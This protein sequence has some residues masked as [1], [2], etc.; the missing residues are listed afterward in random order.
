VKPYV[1]RKLRF[2]ALAPLVAIGVIFVVPALVGLDGF[3]WV[4]IAAFVAFALLN[5]WRATLVLRVDADGVQVQRRDRRDLARVPWPSI[6]ELVLT[7]TD[8]PEFAI[9]LKRGAPLPRGVHGVIHDPHRP[10]AT[11]PELRAV[12]PRGD[13]AALTTAVAGR[14]P[15][16]SA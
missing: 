16:R 3:P 12:L 7:E 4:F 2:G 13:R 9:R 5:A 8:P 10:D 1:V 6:H 15:V 14:V 11:A